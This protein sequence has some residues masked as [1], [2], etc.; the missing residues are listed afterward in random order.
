MKS[1]KPDIELFETD[2][3]IDELMGRV[4]HGVI[5]L[6]RD[7]VRTGPRVI[8]EMKFRFGGSAHVC[9]GMMTKAAQDIGNSIEWVE[10][11]GDGQ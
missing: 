6:R 8:H 4:T 10:L 3:L 5:V 9:L 1:K 2:D 11:D 7:E